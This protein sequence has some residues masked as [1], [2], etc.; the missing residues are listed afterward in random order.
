MRTLKSLASLML[1]ST[2]AATSFTLTA[3]QDDLSTEELKANAE[4]SARFVAGMPYFKFNNFT[5]SGFDLSWG[6]DQV[7]LYFEAGLKKK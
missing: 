3:C 6:W 7:L 5:S 1:M 2:V 4:K